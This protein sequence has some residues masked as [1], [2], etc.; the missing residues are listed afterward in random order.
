M[1]VREILGLPKKNIQPEK[2]AEELLSKRDEFKL[3]PSPSKENEEI[4]YVVTE[5]LSQG[6]VF[7]IKEDKPGLF[8]VLDKGSISEEKR[9]IRTTRVYRVAVMELRSKQHGTL[10]AHASLARLLEGQEVGQCYEITKQ[11]NAR[12]KYRVRK[13]A[14]QH[15]VD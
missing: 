11:G 5:E 3:E 1:S 10:V 15:H 8:E 2:Q 9:E 12:Q 14:L 7:R 13:I 4:S 6:V